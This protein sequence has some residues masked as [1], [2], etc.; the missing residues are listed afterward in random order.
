MSDAAAREQ[1]DTETGAAVPGLRVPFSASAHAAS[2]PR[3]L[4]FAVLAK[5]TLDLIFVGA[6]AVYA[7]T[8][9][10]HATYDGSLEHADARGVSGWVLDGARPGSPVEVQLYVDG[11]F[12][13]AGIADRSVQGS[14]PN[15]RLG[16]DFKLEPLPTGEHEARVYAVH[17]SRGGARRTL[18]QIG[19]TLRF[20][21][22]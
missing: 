4:L 17:T 2:S 22:N 9:S 13:G 6:L 1:T 12:A 14:A 18:Q 21:S 11:R 16:F 5:L 10:F 3:S 15:Q 19:D 7:H 20:V 8:V